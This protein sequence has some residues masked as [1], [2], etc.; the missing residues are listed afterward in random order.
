MKSTF[1]MLAFAT[2]YCIQLNAQSPWINIVYAPT[3]WSNGVPYG[4][5]IGSYGV[6]L[7]ANGN[8]NIIIG[9]D[10]A[11]NRILRVWDTPDDYKTVADTKKDSHFGG[12]ID[13]Y[14]GDSTLDVKDVTI[15]PNPTSDKI[16]I[17]F[18]EQMPTG[19]TIELYNTEGKRLLSQKAET[20][21]TLEVTNYPS[22]FYLLMLRSGKATTQWKISKI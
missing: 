6:G 15:F 21:S 11:G 14:L 7:M 22:G 3:P 9:Y 1:L 8:Q 5:V 10:P 20:L 2:F 12:I 13:S 4:V 18:S 16:M 19:A 17:Q